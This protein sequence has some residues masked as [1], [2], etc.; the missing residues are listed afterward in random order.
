MVIFPIDCFIFHVTKT[1]FLQFLRPEHTIHSYCDPRLMDGKDA[2]HNRRPS[3]F[4]FLPLCSNSTADR[5]DSWYQIE[6]FY[7]MF[8][9]GIRFVVL[10]KI[11]SWDWPQGQAK[12]GEASGDSGKLAG[13]TLV[14]C[15]SETA[16]PAHCN[17]W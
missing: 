3:A 13:A 15:L 6:Q 4:G 11:W 14:P 7:I 12:A 2:K 5:D 8:A 9:V 10:K 16:T 17:L 1:D